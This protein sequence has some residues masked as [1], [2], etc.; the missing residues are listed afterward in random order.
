MEIDREVIV[1]FIRVSYNIETVVKEIE[2]S[3]LLNDF[4]QVLRTRRDVKK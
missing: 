2:E 4:A 1:E 3:Q